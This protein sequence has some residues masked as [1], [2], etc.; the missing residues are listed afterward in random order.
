MYLLIVIFAVMLSVLLADL[1][2]QQKAKEEGLFTEE[3]YNSED[4]NKL[5]K[6]LELFISK[7]IK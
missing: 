1:G 4:Q 7:I 2:L 6:D 5:Q 3:W